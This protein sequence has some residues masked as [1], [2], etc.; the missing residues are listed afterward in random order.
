MRY[1]WWR[2]DVRGFAAD[3]GLVK[4][5]YRGYEDDG[6]DEWRPL[7]QLRR[8]EAT[9]MC[10]Y[11]HMHAHILPCAHARAPAHVATA[12]AVAPP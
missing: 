10:T 5:R 12:H 8:H 7:S 6:E 1:A 4:V 3:T 2:G 9:C 11:Y